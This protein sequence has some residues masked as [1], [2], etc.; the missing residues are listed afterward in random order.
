MRNVINLVCVLVLLL[1]GTAFSQ[2]GPGDVFREFTFVPAGGQFSELDPNCTRDFSQEHTWGKDKPRMVPKE[3]VIDLKGATKA[4]MCVEY[5]G[6]HSGTSE[7]KFKVNGNNWIY[8]PQPKN[9]PTTPNCYY[10]TLLGNE[11]VPIPLEHLKDGKNIV[12]FFAGPQICYNFNFGFYWIYSFTVRVYYDSSRPH[13]TG[14]IITP[15]SGAVLG[16]KPL[17][18]AAASSSNSSVKSV[19]FIGCYEDFNWEGNGIYRQWHYQTR[20]GV[21]NKHIGT[22]TNTPYTVTWDNTW[23]PDQDQPIKIMAKITDENGISY[24]TP[25]IENISLIH[26]DRDIKMYKPFDVPE[27]FG[28]RVKRTQS[29]KIKI[30][31]EPKFAKSAKMLL[32]TWSAATDDGSVHKIMING[33][34]LADNFGVLHN[35]SFDYLDVPLEYLKKGVNEVSIYSQFEGHALEINWPGPVLL[36]E[37]APK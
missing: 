2:P 33:K 19:D 10:R 35:Y 5:W 31:D 13:P 21:I 37:Y 17:I 36:I 14:K 29:C 11:A 4:E 6:G 7:Q 16:D 32:S 20:H 28:V 24:M 26:P 8:I 12:Q 15:A 27:V 3:I 18:T 9:T 22:T 30:D 23:V 34:D 1:A 25:V